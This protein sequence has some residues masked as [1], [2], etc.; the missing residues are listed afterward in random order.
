MATH[1]SLV[2]ER[3]RTERGRGARKVT[4]LPRSNGVISNPRS[5]FC[6]SVGI[7]GIHCVLVI[8]KKSWWNEVCMWTIP[9]RLERLLNA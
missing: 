9:T 5:F 3:V 7:Y 6:A 8:S 2:L 4:P 1:S